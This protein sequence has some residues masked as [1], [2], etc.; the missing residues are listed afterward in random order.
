MRK[1][2]A[3]WMLDSEPGIFPGYR[4]P[5]TGWHAK[6]RSCRN[7]PIHGAELFATFRSLK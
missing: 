6:L 5:S 2:D 4:N 1:C 7:H 3:F